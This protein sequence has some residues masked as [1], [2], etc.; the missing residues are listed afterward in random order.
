MMRAL[1]MVL[2]IASAP[3]S[4]ALPESL[5]QLR[6]QQRILIVFAPR[7]SDDRAL[8]FDEIFAA[9]ACEVRDRELAIVRVFNENDASFNGVALNAGDARSLRTHYDVSD[10]VFA[11][12]L[13]G[14]DGGEKL[15]AGADVSLG[16]LFARIDRMPMRQAEMRARA[17]PCSDAKE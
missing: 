3:A 16:D 2:A 8:A 14:K 15:R 7:E 12:L 5:L 9:R 10:K 6:W 17:A 1:A 11:V 13:V 4:S